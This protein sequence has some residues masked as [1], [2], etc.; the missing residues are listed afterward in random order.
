MCT[1]EKSYLCPIYAM[2]YLHDAC[3][4]NL[5]SHFLQHSVPSVYKFLVQ[6]FSDYGVF[7]GHLLWVTQ[8]KQLGLHLQFYIVLHEPLKPPVILILDVIFMV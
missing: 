2:Y 4:A 7:M 5:V 1:T 6:D 8:F 3:F